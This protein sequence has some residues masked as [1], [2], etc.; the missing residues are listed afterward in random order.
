MVA[1]EKTKSDPTRVQGYELPENKF[2]AGGADPSAN[3]STVA[4][5][6]GATLCRSCTL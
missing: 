1:K 5:W 3:G 6:I 4:Y 2:L